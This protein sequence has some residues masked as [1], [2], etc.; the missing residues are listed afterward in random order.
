[1]VLD[2]AIL[3]GRLTSGDVGR[4]LEVGD[5]VT[6]AMGVLDRAA[7]DVD[8]GMAVASSGWRGGAAEGFLDR[9]RRTGAALGHVYGLLGRVDTAVRG[10]AAAY[11]ALLASADRIY[12]PWRERPAGADAAQSALLA[13]R[14]VFG[15]SLAAYGYERALA[16]AL[17]GLTAADGG[18]PGSG[19]GPLIPHTL[20]AGDEDGEWIPQGLAY[21]P[22]D[23]Q[24]LLSYYSGH[25]DTDSLLSVLDENSGEEVTH[26]RLGGLPFNPFSTAPNHSGGVAVD[27]D[28]VWVTSSEGDDRSYVYRY[29][30]A[31]IEAAGAGETVPATGKFEVAASSY[32][33]FAEGRLWVGSF[34]EHGP[35]AL[36]S[37][38]VDRNGA[39]AGTP[40]ETH[41]VPEKIQGV[42]VRD[43][44]FILSQSY[45]RDNTSSLL[46]QGRDDPFGYLYP[47]R[48]T[49][50]NMA[51]GI[52][53]VDGDVVTLYESGAEEYAD[54][55]W[56]SDRMTRTPVEDLTGEDFHV[57][58]AALREAAA[59]F[60]DG[61]DALT[62]AARL[63]S[64]TQLTAGALGE[65]PAAKP[66]SAAVTA[67]IGACG[68]NL[69]AGARSARGTADG[70]IGSAE[71]YLRI[72]DA[73]R[74]VFE[75]FH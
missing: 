33:T 44:E 55:D 65:V 7:S 49:M 31:D 37:Y 19:D 9:G 14:V 12:Q 64:C 22:G 39:V 66:F 29:S 46:T 52:A 45:G 54:G 17:G 59:A 13:R 74:T 43:G 1:M 63:M 23:D 34:T 61:A 72:E 35:G 6:D 51:E 50:P 67:R 58:P 62:E 15:L 8:Q 71:G 41:V 60:D 75:L 5:S 42:V 2:P 25:S 10:A 57:E 4:I 70:L 36:Y 56:P 3:Y 11:S 47:E 27:G 68:D 16:A 21:H 20:R 69:G 24:L 38:D 53:E 73:A 26:V 30:L 40:S 32:A 28:T 18:P 48:L